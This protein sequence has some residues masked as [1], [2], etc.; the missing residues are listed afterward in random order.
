LRH[1]HYTYR[2][3]K[4]YCAWIRRYIKFH[5]FNTHPTQTGKVQIDYLND[6][7]S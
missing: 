4:T 2:T 7:S 3:E 1:H 5:G 6:N